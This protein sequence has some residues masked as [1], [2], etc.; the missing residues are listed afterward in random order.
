[1]EKKVYCISISL[2]H[3]LYICVIALLVSC[4]GKEGVG[5]IQQD[6]TFDEFMG[7]CALPDDPLERIQAVGYVRPYILSKW[8]LY[9]VQNAPSNLKIEDWEMAFSPSYAGSWKQ[10]GFYQEMYENGIFNVPTFK[11]SFMFLTNN[12]KAD[13]DN[14]PRKPNEDGTDPNS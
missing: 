2:R 9:D 1:M 10:D 12:S 4:Y 8:Y 13:L 5:P 7:M 6:I 14:K 3:S 11:E